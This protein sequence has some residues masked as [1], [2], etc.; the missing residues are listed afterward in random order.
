MGHFPIAGPL[1]IA[2]IECYTELECRDLGERDIPLPLWVSL[3]SFQVF[4]VIGNIL[5]M[6]LLLYYFLLSLSL[7]A[8][9][10]FIFYLSTYLF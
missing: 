1:L 5:G 8:M 10:P 4:R 3:I 2:W 7:R 6:Y 9:D